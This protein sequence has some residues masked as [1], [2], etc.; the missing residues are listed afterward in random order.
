[1]YI[2]V[3]IYIYIHICMY[4]RLYKY[5]YERLNTPLKTTHTHTHTHIHT[6]THTDAGRIALEMHD[7]PYFFGTPTRERYTGSPR[8]F[9]PK[10][11][12]PYSHA[13]GWV[14]V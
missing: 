2:Y 11:P 4:P 7:S 13:G 14:G 5:A 10:S 12:L 3:Y 9:G 6:H 8:V 1:M